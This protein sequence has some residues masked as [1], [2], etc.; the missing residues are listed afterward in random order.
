MKPSSAGLSARDSAEHIY[1]AAPISPV[2]PGLLLRRDSGG[3][4]Y[5]YHYSQALIDAAKAGDAWLVS[6]VLRDTLDVNIRDVLE[7]TATHHACRG[8]HAEVLE[9]LL[10]RRPDLEARNISGDTALIVATQELRPD[11]IINKHI[12]AT[13]VYLGDEDVQVAAVKA[14]DTA[15]LQT[16]SSTI[17]YPPVDP[18]TPDV[19]SGLLSLTR[20]AETRRARWNGWD[21]AVKRV[22]VWEEVVTNGSAKEAARVEDINSKKRKEIESICKE[23]VESL[24]KLWHPNLLPVIGFTNEP[25]HN[26]SIITE[27]SPMGSL[28]ALLSNPEILI[29]EQAAYQLALGAAQ[30]VAYLHSQQ[31]PIAHGNLKS[32]NILVYKGNQVKLVEFGF[33]M[34]PFATGLNPSNLHTQAGKYVTDPTYVPPEILRGILGS[35]YDPRWADSY[36]FGMVLHE[37]A[38]RAPTWPSTWGPMT[39]GLKVLLENARPELP[40]YV[41]TL[42]ADLIH[43][44]LDSDPQVRPDF[45]EIVGV[46]EDLLRAAEELKGIRVNPIKAPKAT[47]VVQTREGLERKVSAVVE[48]T[49]HGN[50]GGFDVMSMRGSI[51][52]PMSPIEQIGDQ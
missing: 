3:T 14:Q 34:S 22:G 15:T 16:P 29:D 17:S 6:E 8:G 41:P 21:V 46:L 4:H 19:L 50:V 35:D 38:T 9:V 1:V 20:H 13:A 28:H 23:E 24:R 37:V 52:G 47:L 11:L 26:V 43:R 12:V 36:G 51:G 25:P 10:E 40:E 45:R 31:P 32:R 2:S 7:N 5:D 39:I 33:R 42:L 27:L 48:R 44:C 18:S 49:G 30:G